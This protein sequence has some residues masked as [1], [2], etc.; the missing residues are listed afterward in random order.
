MVNGYTVSARDGKPL[1]IVFT[2]APDRDTVGSTLIQVDNEGG[3]GLK[4]P[5]GLLHVASHVAAHTPHTV[6]VIDAAVGSLDYEALVDKIAALKPDVV[7]ITA[8]TD[9]W[10]PVSHTLDLLKMRCPETL[11]VVGG[12]HV[13]VYPE[14]TLLHQSVDAVIAG[15]GE[16]PMLALLDCIEKEEFRNGIS[17][18]HFQ[19]MGI[20]ELLSHEERNL[21]FLTPPD[22]T[23]LPLEPYYSVLGK[24]ALS[25]TMIT[26]RGC[27]FACVYCK[28]ERQSTRMHSAKYVLS[29]FDRIHALGISEVEIYDDTFTWSHERVEAICHGL[30]ERNYG[31]RWAIRD[32]VS[33]V[34]EKTL[35]LMRDAGCTRIHYGIESGDDGVLQ[36][37]KKRITVHEAET[38]IALARKV[39]F[40]VLGFFM[41]GLPEETEEEARRTL[42]LALRLPLD[43]CEFSIT[44]AYPGTVMYREALADGRISSDFWKSYALAPVPCYAP[45]P[46]LLSDLSAKELE[47]LQSEALRRFYFRPKT[48][49]NEIRKIRSLKEF[50]RKFGMGLTVLKS[51]LRL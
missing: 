18:L 44:M 51:S 49:W 38:S 11:T 50:T 33:N 31:I 37:I 36:R 7:G 41:F 5:L 35:R 2:T 47:R 21:E 34:R 46:Y 9:F 15:D 29:E 6:H 4:P 26:S 12:P 39:G 30:I 16:T 10:Y 32:R 40:E 13:L 22:R 23:L 27:P 1:T 45:P 43:Y 20:H 17:G 3:I 42:E 24:D 28:I 14:E 25:T 19:S 48:I 8:W